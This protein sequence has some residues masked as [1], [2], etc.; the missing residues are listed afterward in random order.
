M[1]VKKRMKNP[2]EM[3]ARDM[4]GFYADPLGH[5]MYSY[6]WTSDATI[7]VV[8]LAPEYQDR[9]KSKHGPDVWACEFLDQLGEEIKQRGFNGKQPVKPI[10]FST[11]SGHGIGKSALS[12]WLIKF[13]MDTR[14]LC[15]G[16]VTAVTADQ[17][18]A[19]TWMQVGK[20]HNR[21]VTEHWF[22]YNTGRGSMSLKHKKKGDE[23]C[24]NAQTCREENSEAFAGQHSVSSTS[25]YLFDEASGIPEKIF[26]VREG[27]LTDGEPMV[28]DFGNPTRNSGRFFEN[29]V[30]EYKHRFIVRSIDSRSVKITNKALATEMIEDYGED[31]DIVKVRVKGVFPSASSAQFISNDD[32]DACMKREL[33]STSNAVMLLGVDVAR[34]GDDDSVIYPRC[35]DDA[36][37]FPIEAYNGLDG[38]QLAGKIANTYNKYVDE[39]YEVYIF[40]DFGGGYGGSPVDHLRFLGYNPLEVFTGRKAT[41]EAKYRGKS[42][43]IWGLMKDAI[44]KG[45]CL[46]EPKMKYAADLKKQLTQREYGHTIVGHKIHLEPKQAMKD[47]GIPSPDIADALAMTYAEVVASSSV[48]GSNIKKKQ[49]VESEYNPHEQDW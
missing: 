6:P 10:R 35:G 37:S 16:T 49:Q 24:C 21:S 18:K 15:Q 11:A 14:P 36:R 5:V 27:G 12:A 22:D 29:C 8:E 43:E 20:W 33:E 23:W 28:F 32:V 42:D 31:S 13:L 45:L 26:Q 1:G 47:R 38:V 41:D 40:I 3:I 48:L 30:G 25:F 4:A 7:Q 44:R 17:L 46:P 39:G 2:D 9:F 34:Q 19:K